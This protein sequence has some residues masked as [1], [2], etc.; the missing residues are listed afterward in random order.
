MHGSTIL[1]IYISSGSPAIFEAIV[2]VFWPR[3]YAPWSK[4]LS[5]HQ[6]CACL[7]LSPST[8]RCGALASFC[9]HSPT[10]VPLLHP[11]LLHACLF[12]VAC[13]VSL[14]FHRLL[15]S[16]IMLYI[17]SLSFYFAP[18]KR[19]VSAFPRAPPLSHPPSIV[20]LFAAAYCWWLT[21]DLSLLGVCHKPRCMCLF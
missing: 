15:K 4:I 16:T 11:L 7:L 8:C 21:C 13:C 3:R 2:A 17:F 10:F 5:N 18:S 19:M 6:W 9:C 14:L 12:L 20:P 1:L